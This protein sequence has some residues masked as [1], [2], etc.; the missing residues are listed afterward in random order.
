MV[1]GEGSRGLVPAPRRSPRA[2]QVVPISLGPR[3]VGR[4]MAMPGLVV[5]PTRAR[6]SPPTPSSRSWGG[7]SRRSSARSGSRRR[8]SVRHCAARPSTTGCQ[9]PPLRYRCAVPQH[10]GS[11][12]HTAPDQRSAPN[13]DTQREAV[14]CA[15]AS[16]VEGESED[17]GDR[18]ARRGPRPPDQAEQSPAGR[19]GA[20]ATSSSPAS[21]TPEATAPTLTSISHR[22]PPGQAT[23]G[24]LAVITIAP[25]RAYTV[26]HV[27]RASSRPDRSKRA[28]ELWRA[29]RDLAAAAGL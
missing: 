10:T 28:C 20:S 12:R 1:S 8:T 6:S 14:G 29:P 18:E 17:L 19:G 27:V 4:G 24:S 25:L 26:R 5:D 22:V 11:G 23:H 9:R 21:R 13:L 3:W 16:Q 7:Q 2:R 15:G